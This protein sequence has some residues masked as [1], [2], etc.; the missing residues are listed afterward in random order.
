MRANVG[1]E[2]VV[3]GHHVGDENREA[4]IIE[5]HGE[6]GT[7]PYLVRWRD[8]HQS[9]F[10][11]LLRH[12]GRAPSPWQQARQPHAIAGDCDAGPGDRTWL[13]SMS[14]ARRE[15]RRG[16]SGRDA[17]RGRRG[18]RRA[19]GRRECCGLAGWSVACCLPESW[20]QRGF[21]FAADLAWRRRGTG[22]QVLEGNLRRVIGGEAS[23]GEL[24]ALSR[25]AMRSYA[26][27][28][29]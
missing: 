8:G 26:R 1:D 13:P 17:N 25:Q 20:A 16:A 5:V 3:R 23:G 14:G 18:G 29:A 28:L 10:F 21:R 19:R 27:V 22:V 11:S 9:V 4:V 15:R 24:R 2:L 12:D 7:P 6:E